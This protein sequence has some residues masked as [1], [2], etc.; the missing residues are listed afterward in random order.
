M[1]GELSE[2]SPDNVKQ[3]PAVEFVLILPA[4]TIGWSFIKKEIDVCSK[5]SKTR[6][7][8]DFCGEIFISKNFIGPHMM[9]HSNER[10]WRFNECE[11]AFACI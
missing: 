1:E 2:Y 4:P 8:C 7:E 9:K 6:F 11:L 10:K 3:E 5:I